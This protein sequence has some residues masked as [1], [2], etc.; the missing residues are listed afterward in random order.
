MQ[1]MD[2]GNVWAYFAGPL[3]K[4][5][6]RA[7]GQVRESEEKAPPKARVKQSTKGGGDGE[8]SGVERS[9]GSADFQRLK[10]G[11]AEVAAMAAQGVDPNPAKAPRSTSPKEAAEE[12]GDEVEMW[13]MG[14]RMRTRKR[15]RKRR[16]H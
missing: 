14:Q 11:W 9:H 6:E 2:A 3:A 1:K 10:A 12:E 16:S 7:T 5:S 13:T 4:E 15:R 8:S